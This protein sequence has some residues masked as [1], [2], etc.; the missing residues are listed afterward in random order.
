MHWLYNTSK[1][2][3]K[4]CLYI[5]GIGLFSVMMITVTDVIT[6]LLFSLTSGGVDLTIIGSVELVSYLMLLSLLATMAAN[7]EKSQVVV[8]AFTH[9]I[10]EENKQRI[11]GVYLLGFCALGGLLAWGLW[12]EGVNA[13]QFGEVTQDLAIPKGPIYKISALLSIIFA[14]RCSIQAVLGITYSMEGGESQ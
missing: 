11:A 7:V 14:L 9:K 8:E 5:G 12:E 13:S 1:A 6:R 2:L 10:S 3:E 4:I